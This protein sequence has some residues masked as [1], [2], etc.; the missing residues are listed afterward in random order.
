[1]WH[2]IIIVNGLLWK[3][4][5][6]LPA[7]SQYRGVTQVFELPPILGYAITSILPQYLLI[8]PLA[9]PCQG[10]LFLKPP[11]LDRI[12]PAA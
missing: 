4:A 5:A 2:L 9:A 11:I 12:N 10:R 3:I 8:S 7:T 6:S 1:M